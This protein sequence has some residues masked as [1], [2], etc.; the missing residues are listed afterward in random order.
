MLSQITQ[1]QQP[2][3]L[4]YSTPLNTNKNNTPSFKS[5]GA[6]GTQALNFLNTSP[7]IGACFVDFFS[8][9]MPRTLVDFGRSKDAGMETGFR[10]SSGTINHA[11]AGI[12]GLGAG[13]AVSAAFN[14]ANGV[15]AH[16]LFANSDAIDT[17]GQLMADSVANGKY[18]AK[19]Y[20]EQFFKGL[21]GFNTTDGANSWKMLKPESA[22]E[23][24][25]IMIDAGT[26]KYKAPKAAIAK[27]IEIVTGET[28]AGSTFKLNFVKTNGEQIVDKIPTKVEGS[29][30]N[31]INN[32]YAMRKTVLDK[33]AHDKTEIVKD[34]EKFLKGI[35]GRKSAT[36]AAGL[37]IPV[38]IGMSSQPFNRYLTKKR[39]G[40][41]GFVGVEGREPDKSFGFKVLKTVLGLALGTAM[42]SCIL[43][44]PLALVKKGALKAWK[45]A[46]AE[47]AKKLQYKGAVPTMDQFKFI[48][49][50]T[51][52]SRIFAARD[53]NET[54]ES[55]IKDTLGFA[56]WLILGGFVSKLA[57]KVF[58]K[59]IVNY[60]KETQGKGLWNYITKSVEKTHEEILYPELQKL[61]IK[62]M[63]GDKK[64]PFRK[65]MKEVKEI[66]KNGIGQ[67]QDIAKKALTKLKYK[68]YVQLLGY[69]YS[70]V[71]LGWGIPKLNIAITNAVEGKKSKKSGNKNTSQDKMKVMPAPLAQPLE[72]ASKTFSAFGAYLN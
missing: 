58:D 22:Q 64:I 61:K 16:L 52:M 15:K 24:A 68:N 65:L 25:K 40:S 13:Y 29:I 44:N 62:V 43:K 41:D 39:T 55:A 67:N 18:D 51:I 48:Y 54:R 9:V 31:L 42:V 57:A 63:D 46:P 66:A 5:L 60:D 45:E 2:K 30:D 59:G 27:A 14:K 6:M 7:A 32:A 71:V 19:Q 35:K 36:V 12:V 34:F 72:P 10:E 47:I 50:M 3:T 23:A 49:G 70:G 8:M 21:E 28:G 4:K 1:T 20:W 17:F 33:A 11:L 38:I 26:E 53:K 69:V 37:A 56:N